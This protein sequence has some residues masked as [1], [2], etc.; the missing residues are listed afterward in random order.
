MYEVIAR[1]IV[2]SHFMCFLCV[3]SKSEV[4]LVNAMCNCIFKVLNFDRA[5]VQAPLLSGYDR[6]TLSRLKLSRKKE[7]KKEHAKHQSDA[8]PQLMSAF[9]RTD[10]GVD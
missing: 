10:G 5:I 9:Q 3:A 7:R 8:L 2:I 6:L 1:C 4:Q